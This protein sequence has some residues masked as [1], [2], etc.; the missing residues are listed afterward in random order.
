MLFAEVAVVAVAVAAVVAALCGVAVAARVA[1]AA[2]H[3]GDDA[4]G[5]KFHYLARDASMTNG[6][7]FWSWSS[8]RE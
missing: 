3:A 6:S 7:P 2:A 5:A 1:E 4:A 8:H